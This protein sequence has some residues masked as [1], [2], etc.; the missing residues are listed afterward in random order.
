M[1]MNEETLEGQILQF[2]KLSPGET[3]TYFVGYLPT[4]RHIH[5]RARGNNHPG[6]KSA[7]DIDAMANAFHLLF[8]RG[9]ACLVQDKHG[10]HDYTYRA[11]RR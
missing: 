9:L 7:L 8:E 10:F 4:A 11:V 5:K 1:N 2:K 3:M 6:T